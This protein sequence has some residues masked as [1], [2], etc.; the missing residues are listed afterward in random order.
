MHNPTPNAPIALNDAPL[1]DDIHTLG[2]HLG[3]VIK[4]HAG[5]RIFDLVEEIRALAKARRDGNGEAD[6]RLRQRIA[7]LAPS[8]LEALIRALACFF[9][10]ANLAE[11]RHRVRV[12]RHRERTSHPRPRPES[13]PAAIADL[14][15]KG[16]GPEQMQS[17]MERLEIELVFTAHPT[18]AKRRTVRY[19]LQELR[20]ILIARGRSDLL[21][22]ESERLNEQIA[23]VI[24]CLWQMETL[25]PRRPTV[26][27]EVERGLYATE[28]VWAV[29][30]RVLREMREALAA[31]FPGMHL[32]VPAFLRFGTWIGGDRD[33]NPFVDTN[34]TRSALG[35][36]RQAAL[37]RHISE[38]EHLVRQLS[39]SSRRHRVSPELPAAVARAR[40]AWPRLGPILDALNPVEVYRQW[41]AVIRFRLDQTLGSKPLHIQPVSL[42]GAYRDSLELY[43]DVQLIASSLRKSGLG[44]IAAA[45]LQEWLDR[46]RVFGFHLTRLDIREN[47]EQLEDVV[48]DLMRALD[49]A[50][51]FAE[52]S[53]A[54]KQELLVRTLDASLV[55]KLPLNQLTENSRDLL[56]LF[57]LLHRV[58]ESCGGEPLGA[59]IISM[60]ESASD[61]LSML[62]LSRVGGIL[63]GRGDTPVS[64]PIVPL[65]E[66]IDDL[67]Q[68]SELLD[69]LLQLPAYN[70][71]VQTL[72]GRQ[73]CMIGYSD[74]TKDGG[75]LAANWHLYEAQ[76]RLADTAA[77]HGVR[78]TLF[79]GRGGALGRGG[80][81]AARG[82][83]SLPPAS[84]AGGIRITEQGEVLAERYDDPDIAFRHLEQVT[85]ATILM[86]GTRAEP[87]N[88]TWV[89]LMNQ[90]VDASLKSY[91][92][93]VTDP[94][95]LP[96]FEH[97][98]PI[99]SIETLSIGSRP[100][101]R[102]GQRTLANL[103][104]IPYVFAWTQSRQ[105]I[106]AFYGLGSGFAGFDQTERDTLALMYR[107]WPF[108]RAVVDNAELALAKCD[109]AIAHEYA[110]LCEDSAE[111]DRL[112]TKIRTE[113]D[114]SVQAILAIHDRRELLEDLPWLSRSIRVRN[115]YVDPLNVIQIELLRRVKQGQ[116]SGL[117]DEEL[118]PWRELLRLAVQGVAAGLRTTG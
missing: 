97:A 29:V 95:F 83:L 52:C 66:T 99:E 45:E 90:A 114:K 61:A 6:A 48:D 14:K 7:S 39:L 2:V 34:V 18:E 96:Y 70:H 37:E 101:R 22:R 67:A 87:P 116:E 110:G 56:S 94:G 42:P 10:L 73:V 3:H 11:D 60:T 72:S 65:F 41:L 50:P 23:N 30:P 104:A 80:G 85:W 35:I 113:Y 112:W 68:A 31:E 100:A 64:M 32:E 17:I 27:E 36:L 9:D 5:P 84:V 54:A 63:A 19:M 59:L 43:H 88:P 106:P 33:G 82:I 69:E 8:E 92:E 111:G 102:R 40:A 98:T 46:I 49:L 25:R 74:S 71:H 16:F 62:W 51:A 21:P 86:T 26:L 79:H 77:K 118:E 38:S 117:D 28:S 105:L 115:P 81:P 108:F 78:L 20:H 4:E 75:F 47:A 89:S 76:R 109:M 15:A 93:F 103:R 53:E 55:R 24:T 58:E 91:R 44:E 12:L 13:I 107:E 57:V 1:R